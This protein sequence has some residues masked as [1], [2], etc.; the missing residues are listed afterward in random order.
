MSDIKEISTNTENA[1]LTAS[2]G[3]N[4]DN[5]AT[6]KKKATATAKKTTS[7]KSAT[8]AK[9]TTSTKSA[10]AAKKSTS[11]KSATAAKK[12][13]AKKADA[14]I[15]EPILDTTVEAEVSPI[16]ETE[17]VDATVSVTETASIEA[18]PIAALLA[19][20]DDIDAEPEQ[21]N[22]DAYFKDFKETMSEALASVSESELKPSVDH[23]EASEEA[24]VTEA[25][26]SAID[27]PTAEAV[28]EDVPTEQD[29]AANALADE[30]AEKP[31]E[32]KSAVISDLPDNFVPDFVIPEDSDE[33]AEE[34][35]TIPQETVDE[36]DDMPVAEETPAEEPV[37]EAEE[38]AP[39]EKNEAAT[40]VCEMSD[41]ASVDDG[42]IAFDFE[43]AK[44]ANDLSA[45]LPERRNK[46]KFDP[47]HPRLIDTVFEFVELF[48]FTFISVLLITTFFVRYS[49]VEGGSM[50][51]TLADGDN[52]II[53]GLFY[54]PER[55]DIIVFEDY[56]TELRE[57]LVKRVIGIAG[58]KV[59]IDING[60]VYVNGEL[61]DEPYV[62]ITPGKD[63]T[64]IF[65]TW[66]VGEGELFVLGDHR[67]ISKDSREFGTIKADSVL[68][69]VKLRFYPFD[70]F[71]LID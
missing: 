62:H 65:G 49:T 30:T 41:E 50:D 25:D 22:F 23:N 21:I 20:S 60:D 43:S 59:V 3:G 12:T 9:K 70:K 44:E 32:P 36:T 7:A 58:D 8:T 42:Q 33:T 54:T 71:G 28:A 14:K 38:I 39:T 1:D 35:D 56:S 51:K 63:H 47:E 45:P 37:T 67:D 13:T 17:P 66:T 11:T 15:A 2:A 61:L 6:P 27:E 64:S 10:T 40:P 31:C 46:D 18:S 68:G 19:E 48:A 4:A 55:G 24:S 26:E 5:T 29:T 16:I 52:L 69:E 57:P 34:A 53:S